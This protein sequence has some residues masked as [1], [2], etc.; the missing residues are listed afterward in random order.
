MPKQGKLIVASTRLPV[1]MSRKH[2]GWE[3]KPSAGGLVTALKSVAERRRFEWIG[4]AGTHVPEADKSTVTERLAEHGCCPIFITKQDIEGFYS[5]FSNGTLWPLF[6]GLTDLSTFAQSDWKAYIKV[7]NR[8]ADEISRRAEPGDLIWVHDYQL[9]LV[10][11]LLRQRGVTCPIGFFLHIPFPSSEI[12]RTLPVREE[13][14]RGLL[15]ADF[16]AFHAYEYVS[17]FRK[18]CLRVLGLDS[19]PSQIRTG[20]RRV[21]LGVL[22]IGIDPAEISLMARERDAESELK[23]LRAAYRGKK[24]ILGVDR[25]D[26]TKGIPEKILAFEELLRTNPKWRNKCVLIQVAAPSRTSVDEYQ[27]LKRRV[28]ELVGRVNGRFGSPDHTPLVYINQNVPRSRLVGMYQAADLALVT[29]IRDGMNLVALEYIAARGEQGG[30][31]ILSEFAGAAHL[32][33]GARLIN[34]Y[35]IAEVAKVLGEELE[36]DSKDSSHMLEFVNQNTSMSW[37]N[38]FLDRLEETATEMRPTAERLRVLADPNLERLRRAQHPL[39]L[40]DYDGTLRGYERKPQDAVP[41]QRIRDVLRD[42]AEH[43][44]VYVI[45]GRPAETLERW[46]GDLPIGLVCEHGF[47]CREKDGTWV[48]QK[49]HSPNGLRRVE[50]LFQEFQRRTPGAIVEV[51]RSAVAWHYRSA[52]PEF[53]TFQANELLSELEDVLKRRPYSVL[54]GNRVIEVRHVSATKGRAAEELLQRHPRTD[55][56]FCAGDDRTDEDMMEVLRRRYSDMS[57][58]CWVGGRNASAHFWT[59]SSAALLTELDAL[60]QH[61]RGRPRSGRHS[62][63]GRK[64]RSVAAQ[65]AGRATRQ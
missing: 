42:L 3:A 33:P 63:G 39:V 41:N 64:R 15:G 46:L 16:V 59:D 19:E 40:L 9:A 11:E 49:G 65:A 34:P 22:P 53:G 48:E 12:Y 31:L 50:Q 14:L 35:N 38:R 2:D 58:L 29:P 25:L 18:S 30:S 55:A 28:D 23:S 61:W 43:A 54:R 24:I 27:A 32:L 8:F 7:S 36:N 20:A 60:A 47:A 13:V 26:Y 4:W 51:K 6:H 45:S 56:V 5:G 37:A 44:V 52:D 17:H 10:P 62:G 21:Y 57:V 1:T